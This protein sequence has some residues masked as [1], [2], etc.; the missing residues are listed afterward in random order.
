MIILDEQLQGLGLEDA[1]SR[2][3]RGTVLVVKRVRPGT[4]IKDDAIPALLRQL[5]QPTFVTINS[6]DFWRRIQADR[7]YCIVCLEL[8]VTQANEVSGWL[9]QLFRLPEF[10][11]KGARMG[12]VVLASQRRLRY[13]CTH[14]QHVH[15]LRWPT[16][17][18][19]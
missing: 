4:V 8:P 9:R 15:F 7:A 18:D 5:K 3:Y 17:H 19:G 6:I 13:H 12:K 10:K 1:V 11:T 2:W 14:E 16:F